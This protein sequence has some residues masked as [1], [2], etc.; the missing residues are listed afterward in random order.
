MFRLIYTSVQQPGFDSQ[1]FGLLCEQAATNN[2]K[3]GVTGLLLCN[4]VEFMQC[5]EGPKDVVAGLYKKITRDSRHSDIRLLV[6]E[7]TRE[8]YFNNWAM[9]GLA[10]KPQAV[11]SAESIAYTL[12]DHRLYRP[13]RS[14]GVGAADLIYEYAKV[15]TELEKAGEMRLLSKVFEVY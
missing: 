10:T 2:R 1:A 9:L 8:L 7:P 15:K 14:L 3:L 12:L 6:S 5:L 4:G 11:L 13:W